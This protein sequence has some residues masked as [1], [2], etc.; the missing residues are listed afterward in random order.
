MDDVRRVVAAMQEE[1]ARLLQLRVEGYETAIWVSRG[2]SAFSLF[3]ALGLLI[4]IYR[5]GHFLIHE[6]IK[7]FVAYREQAESEL[8]EAKRKA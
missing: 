3:I 1:E 8:L 2:L 6:F 4:V 5:R 7:D